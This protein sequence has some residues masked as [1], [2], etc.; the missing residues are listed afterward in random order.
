MCAPDGA[1]PWKQEG[2]RAMDFS[3]FQQLAKAYDRLGF[4]GAL[5]ATGAHDVWVL[6]AALLAAPFA[7]ASEALL[8]DIAGLDTQL[9]LRRVMGKEALYLSLLRKFVAGHQ[10]GLAPLT[11]ALAAGD[12]ATAERMAHTLKGVA[13]NIGASDLQA[14]MAKV[15]LALHD[16]APA[17]LVQG[18]LEQPQALLARLLLAALF[19]PAGISKISGFAGTAGYIG[20]VGLPMPELGASIAI[21]V[22]VLGGIALLAELETL[23]AGKPIRDTTGEVTK[24]AEM[25]EYYA[26][27]CDKLHGEVIPVPTSHLNYTR[28]EPFGTV[29][30]I[31]PWNAPIFTAGWQIAPA[32]CAGNAAVL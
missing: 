20:S 10:T 12:V 27:W 26:G 18:L 1:Y 31:T 21:A 11:E 32:I 28:P 23:S 6:A 30:Q 24:V 25:F 15:E 17:A 5:F 16:Q 8:R 7:A 29:V 4:T 13:G 22:E 3:Y 2:S 9:G 19:L 14:A